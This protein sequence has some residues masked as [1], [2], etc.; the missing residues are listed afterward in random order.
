MEI[1]C[2]TI[3]QLVVV[4]AVYCL[5]ELCDIVDWSRDAIF[6]NE[7]MLLI[8]CHQPIP[9]RSHVDCWE[10]GVAHSSGTACHGGAPRGLVAAAAALAPLGSGLLGNQWNAGGS[11]V[12]TVNLCSR[13]FSHSAPLLLGNSAVGWLMHDVGQRQQPP[14]QRGQGGNLAGIYM[15]AGAPGLRAVPL[16]A[17]QCCKSLFST[18]RRAAAHHITPNSPHFTKCYENYTTPLSQLVLASPVRLPLHKQPQPG[19]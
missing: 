8:I 6:C 3:R 11:G 2:S 15:V 17:Q 9:D 19:A 16:L 1:G 14:P 5:A 12:S 7:C 10:G 4:S 13:L 18:A